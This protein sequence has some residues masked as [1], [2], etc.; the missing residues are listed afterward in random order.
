MRIKKDDTPWFYW[1]NHWS[2]ICSEGFADN[3]DGA[4]L[5]CKKLGYQSGKIIRDYSK[6]YPVGAFQIG[7]C[8]RGDMLE[9]CSGGFNDYML[10]EACN[11]NS[12][13]QIRIGCEGG[14]DEEKRNFSCKGKF[15][16]KNGVMLQSTC[17]NMALLQY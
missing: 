14:E 16:R 5:F 13:F 17:Y 15:F 12:T 8:M 10:T 1:N 4:T 7:N 2:P 6:R 9:S 3:S 11:T